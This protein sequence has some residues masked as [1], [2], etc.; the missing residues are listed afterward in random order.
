MSEL[1]TVTFSYTKDATTV[2]TTHNILVDKVPASLLISGVTTLSEGSNATNLTA[3]VTYTDATSKVVSISDW[4]SNNTSAAT[5]GATTGIVT[6]AASVT[7]PQAVTM[8]CS[9]TEGGVTVSDT[10]E[11]TIS[12]TVKIP[13]SVAITG[14]ATVNEG[15]N[16]TYAA[17]VTYDDATTEVHTTNLAGTWTIDNPLAG[18]IGANTGVLAATEVSGDVSAVIT[19]T[20]IEASVQVSNTFNVTVKDVVPVSVAISGPTTVDE[21]DAPINFGAIVTFNNAAT[22]DKT[23]QGTWSIDNPTAGSINAATG[24]FTPASSFLDDQDVVISYSYTEDGQTVT[25]TF[26][27][28]VVDVSIPVSALISGATTAIAGGAAINLSAVVTFSDSTSG[29][30]TTEGT[31]STSNPNAGTINAATGVFTPVAQ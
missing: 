28:T 20:Y 14:P 4:A 11:I 1:T 18:T 5:I 9:Y 13:V 10:H 26:N 2:T 6:S 27:L 29:D 25:Q 12:D 16:G 17:T 30:K 3:T 7:S 23:T 15:N 19:F 21:G 22:S 8:S 31:W 24:V